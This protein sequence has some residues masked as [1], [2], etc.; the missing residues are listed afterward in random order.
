VTTYIA[1]LIEVRS[2]GRPHSA[3]TEADDPDRA[4]PGGGQHEHSRHEDVLEPVQQ[5][6]HGEP[7]HDRG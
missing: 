1:A 4:H 5:P 3:S 2:C 7:D 6:L